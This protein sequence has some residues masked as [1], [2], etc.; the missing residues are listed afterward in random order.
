[1]IL[2]IQFQQQKYGREWELNNYK[3]HLLLDDSIKNELTNFVINNFNNQLIFR[4]NGSARRFC[5]LNEIST[6][7]TN[8]LV[9]YRKQVYNDFGVSSFEEEP[10]F[11]IFL[12]VNTETGFVHEHMDP[13]KYGF[14]HTRINFLVSK[15]IGGG[16]P[17][18]NNEEFIID[19]GESWINLA[20]EWKHKSTPVVGEKPRIVLSLGA[21]VEKTQLDPILKE[22]GIE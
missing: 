19:E 7:I 22:M 5:I 9:N 18:I 4:Q 14:Y 15:P 3:T 21:L 2:F 16:F 10:L 11:G 1:M 8:L 12:G 17:V 20:S 6:P 13:T